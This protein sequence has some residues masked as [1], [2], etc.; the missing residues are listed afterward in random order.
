MGTTDWVLMHCD[1]L[2]R[3]RR[4]GRPLT[5]PML[6]LHLPFP[7]GVGRVTV[8]FALWADHR[9]GDEAAWDDCLKMMDIADYVRAEYA[10]ALRFVLSVED[11]RIA[12]GRPERLDRLRERG[13]RF[14][15]TQWRGINR[16]GGGY[17]TH[18]PL[19]DEGRETLRYA[20][21]I[22]MIPDI[23]HASDETARE[24][25]AIAAESGTPVV[26]THSNARA[27]AA[28]RRNLPDDLARA[29]GES[30]GVIGL[31]FVPE[32]VGGGGGIPDLLRHI[33]HF[34]QIGL[35]DCLAIGTDFDGTDT[36]IRGIDGTDTLPA[37]A[38]ALTDAYGTDGAAALLS[39][40]AVR[41]FPWLAP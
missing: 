38:G 41:H 11:A 17:D 6:H 10:D 8:N 28:H 40:N 13:V 35:G 14:L 16:L 23:S 19:T 29:V 37:L 18:M 20:I 12:A 2:Y 30:G 9:L 27:Q 21:G 22:G 4:E 39:G 26:A 36:L 24:T 34:R 5:D 33:S 25:L 31:C 3:M 1:T 32:H 7:E 15:S